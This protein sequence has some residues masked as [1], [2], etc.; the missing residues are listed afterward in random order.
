MNNSS[1][2][3]YKKQRKASKKAFLKV[4]FLKKKKKKN[5]NMIV[6]DSKIFPNMKNKDRLSIEKIISRCGKTFH[7]DIQMYIKD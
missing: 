1:T 5:S 7:E 3:Y 6:T 2:K 4:I